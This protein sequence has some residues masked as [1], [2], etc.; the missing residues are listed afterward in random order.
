MD[1]MA[2][3]KDAQEIATSISEVMGVDVV[4]VDSALQRVADTFHYPY[5]SIEVRET[6]IIGRIL[7]TGRPLVVDNK[8]FFQTCADC[9]DRI[10]CKM[11]GLIGVPILFRGETVGAIGL[12]VEP[13]N[14]RH[15]VENTYLVQAFLQQMADLLSSKLEQTQSYKNIQ[16]MSTQWEYVLNTVDSGIVLLDRNGCIIVHNE[17][18]CHLFEIP[19][20]CYNHQLTEYIT[21][22]VITEALEARQNVTDR[23]LVMPLGNSA[24]LGQ[25]QI[26]QM[27][28]KDTYCGAVLSFQDWNRIF[29]Q[30]VSFVGDRD[31]RH[32][33]SELCGGE[34]AAQLRQAIQADT[35][36]LLLCGNAESDSYLRNLAAAIHESAGREGKFNYVSHED[37]MAAVPLSFDS[38]DLSSV[39]P[40]MLIAHKGTLCIS[41]V[42]ELPVIQQQALLDYLKRSEN[43][44]KNLAFSTKLIF[45]VSG[46]LPDP[47]S[48]FI[49]RELLERLLPHKIQL[50]NPLH[51]QKHLRVLF[52][53]AFT[54]YM[55]GYQTGPLK[56]ERQAWTELLHFPW[57]RS[58]YPY[59]K[60][61][62]N[63]VRSSSGVISA[64]QTH[65]LLEQ[66]NIPVK[67]VDDFEL[68]QIRRLLNEGAS[69]EQIANNLKISRSTLY[70]RI[71]KYNLIDKEN[72]S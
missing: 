30:E 71:K 45:T 9:K 40:A 61:I 43:S 52:K 6:S 26:E 36:A 19:D 46:A 59:N 39:P 60:V 18:F 58:L 53:K 41:Q 10:V 69:V 49:C 44:P 27:W 56:I 22:P 32:S 2:V 20:E 33:L 17:Y 68:E 29:P 13:N 31:T 62:E 12:V 47:A 65:Q 8:D 57:E 7:K 72:E 21:H 16:Q 63:L 15:L 66:L 55:D 24:F 48:P 50:P 4:I 51:R 64:L 42:F 38:S 35:Q 11:Q 23:I 34:P 37:W 5:R 14:I 25:L 3:K 54:D 28:Q 70:R 1:L 67:S